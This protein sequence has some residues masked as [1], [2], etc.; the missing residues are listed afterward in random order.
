ME[1]SFIID[2]RSHLD[3]RHPKED[4]TSF[5]FVKSDREQRLG[6]RRNPLSSVNVVPVGDEGE[7]LKEVAKLSGD[8]DLEVYASFDQDA[9]ITG[10]KVSDKHKSTS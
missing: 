1:I 6:D 8:N 7:L 10:I 4:R 3:R 9:K 2:R 5:K